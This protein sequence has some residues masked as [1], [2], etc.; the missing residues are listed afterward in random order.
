[1][2]LAALIRQIVGAR[3]RADLTV[4]FDR[5]IAALHEAGFGTEAGQL[6]EASRLATTTSLEIVGEIG[7]AALRVQANVGPVL[8]LAARRRL[9]RL[10]REVRRSWPGLGIEP[11]R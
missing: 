3:R 6:V 2:S 7:A 10:L 8:P 1:V 9:A 11:G 5:A 4:A